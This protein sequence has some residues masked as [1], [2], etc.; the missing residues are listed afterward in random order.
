[1]GQG[2]AESGEHFRQSDVTFWGIAA[3][4]LSALAF[5]CANLGAILPAHTLTGL[6]STRLDGGNLNYLRTQ[7][8]ELRDEATRIRN[9]NSR[10]MN[11]L[12]LAE[13][14]QNAV[15]QR[16]GAI[17][18]SL[19]VLFETAQSP[20]A[21]IDKSFT[22]SAISNDLPVEIREADGGTVAI[23]R[24]PI[25]EAEQPKPIA[26]VPETLRMPAMPL[27]LPPRIVGSLPAP[28]VAFGI[29]LGPQVT[30]Q[31]AFVAWKDIT[32]RAGPLLLG[33]GPLLSG[34]AG[35]EQQRLVA[36]PIGDYEQAEQLCVRMI[37][38]GISCLPVP[39]AGQALPE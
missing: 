31:D 28:A 38:I 32:T 29:A 6:H 12:T 16:V 36:G 25:E 13:Q 39:Y 9:D 14:D 18:S 11:M 4:V 35:V 23:V 2:L 15:T 34:N 20:A 19:P 30:V 33:L 21:N 17:E 27:P 37:R 22:T 8:A 24:R 3:L 1:M 26:P 7:V 5:L 10:L